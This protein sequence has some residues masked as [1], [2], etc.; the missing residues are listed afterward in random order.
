MWNATE[1]KS[2]NL[3]IGSSQDARNLHELQAAKITHILNVA[4]NVKNH[5]PS[6]FVYENLMVKDRNDDVGVSR[7][8][9]QAFAFYE[10]V[11]KSGGRV[12]VH[13][14][15]GQN[16]SVTVVLSILLRL[17]PSWNLKTCYA[18]LQKLRPWIALTD[19]N[20]KEITAY[21]LKIRGS[22]SMGWKDW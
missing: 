17:Y 5:Y 13:C 3:F 8:F 15:M 2:E 18:H 22:N 7:V 4:D 21:E 12:L 6:H 10:L 20:R 9:D 16:R 1:L 11:I 19:C 14:M